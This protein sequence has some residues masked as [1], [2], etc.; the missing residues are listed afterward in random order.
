MDIVHSLAQGRRR[1]YGER[2]QVQISP[3][4]AAYI[5]ASGGELW[6]WAARPRMCCSGAPAWMRAATSEPSGI[7]G[8]ATVGL[9]DPADASRVQLH[10]RP[11]AGRGP[12]VLEVAMAGRG[13]R[14]VAAFWD[15]CMMAM[16]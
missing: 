3:E 16:V 15:G 4:A 1:T 12:D 8:F 9:A 14:K 5:G 11:V 2:V 6:V 13:H 7:V 10:F